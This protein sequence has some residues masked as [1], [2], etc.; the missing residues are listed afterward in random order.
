MMD[1]ELLD[2]LPHEVKVAFELAGL[3]DVTQ[4]KK[5]IEIRT[6]KVGIIPDSLNMNGLDGNW[7][8]D[9][10]TYKQECIWFIN[11]II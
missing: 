1:R 9:F 6:K 5:G 2:K 11:G 3:I 8:L 7:D 10:D 4:E